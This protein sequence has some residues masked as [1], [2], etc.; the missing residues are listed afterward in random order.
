MILGIGV[1]TATIAR[2]QKS[3]ASKSFVQRFF[4]SAEAAELGLTATETSD[5]CPTARCA[6]HAAAVFAA[7][8]ALGKALGGGLGAFCWPQAQVLH[9]ASGAPYFA[10]EGELAQTLAR[11]QARVHLSLTHEGGFA[12]AFVVIETP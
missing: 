6:E 1:D 9:Q 8:E 10:L 12:T 11:Q 7:K 2:L 3:L 5:F 4:G